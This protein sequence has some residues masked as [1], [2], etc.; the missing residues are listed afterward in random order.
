MARNTK[1][2]FH[3]EVTTST[4][5]WVAS[6][7]FGLEVA[8]IHSLRI[9]LANNKTATISLEGK[10]GKEGVWEDIVTKSSVNKV[11]N[12]DIREFSYVRIYLQVSEEVGLSIFGYTSLDK[13]TQ[14]VSLPEQ[15]SD[16]ILMSRVHLQDILD[17]LQEMNSKL[18]I[19]NEEEL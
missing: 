16:N 7:E 14:N 1:N 13:D 18:N 3:R 12:I 11:S 17:V 6:D 9:A 5:G 8:D 4:T 2:P 10:V 19:L 15:D